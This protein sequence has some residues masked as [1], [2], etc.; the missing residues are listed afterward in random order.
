VEL[1]L[2]EKVLG[3]P[4]TGLIEK[5]DFPLVI[6]SGAESVKGW[7]VSEL[8]GE[9]EIIMKN[10]SGYIED[11]PNIAGAAIM[12]SGDVILGLNAAD[13]HRS[14][15]SSGMMADLTQTEGAEA[16][17]AKRILVADDSLTTRTLEKLILTKA[18]Y[19]V[20]EAKDGVEALEIVQSQYFDL[21]LSDVQMPRMNG[22]EL[23]KKIRQLEK[24]ADIPIVIVSFMDKEPA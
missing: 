16:K 19:E 9:Q 7:V 15:L 13:L 12:G 20:V 14:G 4:S 18:G 24:I 5:G 3:L 10:F 2:L 1:I 21:V 6:S 8:V 17:K 23:S 22:I 11:I